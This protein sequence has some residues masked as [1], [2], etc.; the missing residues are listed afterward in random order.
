MP[1]VMTTRQL[2]RENRRYAS[3]GG[4][5]E[6]NSG[7]GFRPAFRDSATGVL[8]L[9]RSQNGSLAPFHCL[10]GLPTEL[11]E[12]RDPTGRVVAV[13]PTIEAGFERNGRF[14]TR[15]EAAAVVSQES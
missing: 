12:A 15:A 3:T 11:V 6:C 8:Y 5:S 13:K 10:D 2:A 1:R 9:S 7:Q 4:V 14:Y